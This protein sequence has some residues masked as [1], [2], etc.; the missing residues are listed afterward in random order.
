MPAVNGL[1][2][3]TPGEMTAAIWQKNPDYDAD[4]F[5]VELSCGDRV[6]VAVALHA[7]SGGGHDIQVIVPTETG[8]NDVHGESWGDW[9]WNDVEYYAVIRSPKES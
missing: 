1:E 7:D 3:K 2:L 4:R 5:T 6:L 8:F 9:D